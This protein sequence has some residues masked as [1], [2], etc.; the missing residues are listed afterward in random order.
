[1]AAQIRNHTMPPVAS[2]LTEDQRLHRDLGGEPPAQNS[3]HGGDYAGVP[4][5]RL[6]RREY[7]NDPR[8][9]GCGPGRWPISSR[10]MNPAARA[11]STNGET[12]F[13]PP[14]LLERYLESAQKILDRVIITP[15]W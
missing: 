5:R 1:M 11:S 9:V 12:L 4:A 13:V 8:S 7:R 6:N 3:L 10:L 2:K 15:R 14:M